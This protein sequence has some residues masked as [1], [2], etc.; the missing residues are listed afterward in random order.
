[1]AGDEILKWLGKK[2]QSVENRNM[3]AYRLAGDEFTLLVDSSDDTALAKLAESVRSLSHTTIQLDELKRLHISFSIGIVKYPLHGTT[4][5]ELMSNADAAMYYVKTRSKNSW[6]MYNPD[7]AQSYK[8]DLLVEQEVKK[9]IEEKRVYMM[10]QPLYNL[11]ND[12]V[13][14]LSINADTRL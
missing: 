6:E 10:F 12:N 1:M 3:R 14:A 4:A 13:F 11:H 9:S 5:E 8:E 7:K 2:L